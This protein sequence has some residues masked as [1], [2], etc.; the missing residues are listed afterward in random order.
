MNKFLQKNSESLVSMFLGALVVVLVAV[1]AFNYFKNQQTINQDQIQSVEELNGEITDS[2]SAVK[3]PTTHTVAA[4]ETL[5]SLAEKY[6]NN[7]FSYHEIA[8]ANNISNAADLE[9]GTKLT[10]PV[11]KVSAPLNVVD[12][13][14]G[15]SYTVVKSDNLWQISVRAYGDGYRWTEIAKAN[16]LANPNFIHAGNVLTIPR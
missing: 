11:A 14:D 7:G 8:D 4:G 13:I 2:A 15:T 3:L 6:Y 16:N 12:R 9:V 5:W 1:L 10:I